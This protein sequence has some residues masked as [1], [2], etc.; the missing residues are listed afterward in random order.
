MKKSL[1][2]ALVAAAALSAALPAYAETFTAPNGVLSI[3]LPNE[4]WKLM[5]DPSK[6]LVFSDG[7]NMLTVEHLSNGEKLP[8]MSV[9]DD[10]YVDV[11]QAVFSTQNEVFIITGSVVDSDVIPDVTNAIMSAKV[12]QYDTKLAVKKENPETESATAAAEAT[13]QYSV[14]AMS[15]TMYATAGVNV[16]AGYSTS[17]A[18]LGGVAQGS[19]VTVTGVVQKNGKDYGWYQVSYNGVTGYISGAF[20]TDKAPASGSSTN[21]VFTGVAKTIYYGTGEAVTVYQATDGSWYDNTGKAYTQTSDYEFTAKDGNVLTIYKPQASSNNYAIGSPFT[22]YWANGNAETLTLYSDGYYYSSGWVRYWD[23]G[24]N[25]FSGMDGTTLYGSLGGPGNQ[26]LHNG[27][28][29]NS[30]NGEMEMHQLYSID[31]GAGVSVTEGGGA[32]YDSNDVRYD[33]DGD[34]YMMD[35]Y[36]NRYWVEW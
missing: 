34:G 32:Y 11:Y 29:A 15:A 23:N 7:A 36:G 10:H 17:D 30:G 13:G 19:S 31:T 1:L 16:R 28:D 2:A 6:W 27:S 25:T 21:I 22:V 18:V 24:D 5:Q 14:A 33:W 9:A 4:N 8:A 20:L 35:Y 12:L 26:D 3:D